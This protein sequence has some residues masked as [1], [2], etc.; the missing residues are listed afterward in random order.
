MHWGG[1]ESDRLTEE[2][3]RLHKA[4]LRRLTDEQLLHSYGL[5]LKALEVEEGKPPNAAMCST[6]SSAG[7]S[8]GGGGGRAKEKRAG[9]EVSLSNFGNPSGSFGS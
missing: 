2:Q 9:R 4:Q 7:G 6:L 1:K 8:C 3:V 5:Y